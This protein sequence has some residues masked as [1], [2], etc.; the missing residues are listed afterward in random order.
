MIPRKTLIRFALL[1]LHRW[2][3]VRWMYALTAVHASLKKDHRC[4]S[5]RLVVYK[6]FFFPLQTTTWRQQVPKLCL[7]SWVGSIGRLVTHDPKLPDP[8]FNQVTNLAI[9]IIDF[10]S[11]RKGVGIYELDV[12]P[13]KW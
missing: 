11:S 10:A 6:K 9:N 2:I 12:F 7:C 5:S 4:A 13:V 3:Y 1:E 8:T